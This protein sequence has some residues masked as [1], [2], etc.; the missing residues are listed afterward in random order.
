[1]ENDPFH[2][3]PWLFQF[4][5]IPSHS[6]ICLYVY[7]LISQD[8]D[9]SQ[10]ISVSAETHYADIKKGVEERKIVRRVYNSHLLEFKGKKTGL[11]C[12]QKIC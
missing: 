6:Q 9:I 10:L 3:I 4:K 1:M 5:E 12:H 7:Y 11:D 2:S 8:M